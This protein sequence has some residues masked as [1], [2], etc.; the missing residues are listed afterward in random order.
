MATVTQKS[1][2]KLNFYLK[3]TCKLILYQ[4]LRNIFK[5]LS[6]SQ[7]KIQKTQI[8]LKVA[9]VTQMVA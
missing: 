6:K 5:S 7:K 4:K 1:Y 3:K 9:T 8:C 2:K